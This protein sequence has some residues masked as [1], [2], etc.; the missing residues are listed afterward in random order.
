M[1]EKL[2]EQISALADNELPEDEHELLVRRFSMDKYLRICWERYHLIGET[3][4]RELPQIGVRGFVDRIMDAL[5][6]EE[7][8]IKKRDARMN[9]YL[10]KSAAGMALAA[11][12]AVVAVYALRYGN[13]IGMR[14]VS[15]P[16]EIVPT[17]ASIQTSTALYGMPSNAAW[18]GN[19]PAVQ[20]QLNN[21]VIN[22]NEMATLIEQQGMLPYFYISSMQL[23]NSPRQSPTSQKSP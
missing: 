17:S 14:T 10:R 4:R 7:A 9:G 1:S 8:L 23:R 12:V 21:Y 3:M 18:N 20:A 2:R 22:H 15:A 5:D 16:S 13:G 19:L 11:C 6:H